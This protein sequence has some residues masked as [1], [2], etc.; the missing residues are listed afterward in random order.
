[1]AGWEWNRFQ[2]SP[3]LE[4]LARRAEFGGFE[5]LDHIEGPTDRE[6]RQM[7]KTQNGW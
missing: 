5:G 3:W 6:I 7:M 1:V 2:Q 4:I